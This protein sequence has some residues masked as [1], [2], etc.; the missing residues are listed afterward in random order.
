MTP[1]SIRAHHF[2]DPGA[3][4]LHGFL[5]RHVERIPDHPAVVE[6]LGPG[7]HSITTYRQL[8]ERMQG[9]AAH[10]EELGL[11]VGDRVILEAD[12]SSESI[13]MLLACSSLG[14]VFIPVSP[15]APELRIQMIA[16]A[17]EPRLYL[18]SRTGI[19]E[20]TPSSGGLGTFGPDGLRL[21]RPP[22]AGRRRRRALTGTDTAYMIFTSGS[23]GQP[24][25]VVM[26]HQSVVAFYRGML[27]YGIVDETGRVATTSPLQFDFSLLDIGLALGSGAAVVPVPRALLRWPRRFLQV[28]SET[29]ATQVNGVPS[30]WRQV[31][32]HEYDRLA[33]LT[34]VRG[35][36][37]CGEEFPVPELRALQEAQP[38]ACIV[39][40]YG[41]TE[42][43]AC[44]F[45][46]VPNPLPVDTKVLSIGH[47]HP[48]AEMFIVDEQG[49]SLQEPGVPGEIHIR[50][51]ALFS[52][53]WADSASSR[54]SLVV[55]PEDPRSG[56]I[57][58]RTGDLAYRG[59]GGELYFC[60][61]VDSQVQIRGN[62][63][64]LGEVER[65]LLEFPGVSAATALVVDD[66]CGEVVLAAF[67]VHT[68]PEDGPDMIQKFCA[69]NL[70]AYMVPQF[71]ECVESLP[72]TSNGKVDR[73]ALI[74]RLALKD[75]VAG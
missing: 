52:G 65:R 70:P 33:A 14:L 66:G 17:T 58:L 72:V 13:A 75:R 31:L 64:E 24:K 10:L 67:V 32:R 44:S 49:I 69:R 62:R 39:N 30:I 8:N 2:T 51:P 18:R 20:W 7:R 43:M 63:V 5:L 19:R 55:D 42:S 56:R 9:Y 15:E 45:T 3:E 11:D 59:S 34:A 26:S 21:S 61:R 4:T 22:E 35:V 38:Q 50:T 12:T 46:Q 68:N 37:F 16:Q 29:G 25:G 27:Q 6:Y 54:R 40:C 73:A 47:A 48:G 57:V 1:D 41:S 60:G 23:T 28:L 74:A 71:V 53:Y 36:L